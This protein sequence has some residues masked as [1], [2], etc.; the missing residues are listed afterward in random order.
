[1]ALDMKGLR[2]VV[3]MPENVAQFVLYAYYANIGG[4]FEGGKTVMLVDMGNSATTVSVFRCEKVLLE[5]VFHFR[6]ESPHC[7]E[8]LG[9]GWSRLHLLCER[10][11]DRPV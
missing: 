5:F 6:T 9:I 1:M 3:F 8:N 2:N 10:G 7:C 4:E 11:F